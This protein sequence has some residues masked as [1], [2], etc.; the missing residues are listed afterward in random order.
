LFSSPPFV[1][2][3]AVGLF[4]YPVAL[5]SWNVSVGFFALST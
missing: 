5:Y 1:V 2:V 4:L 3:V